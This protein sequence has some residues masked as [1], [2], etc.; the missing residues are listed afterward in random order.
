MIDK[1]IKQL[2]NKFVELNIDGYII[3]KNDEFFS[4]YSAINRLKIISN[5]SGSAGL[6]VV[7][8]KNNYLFVDGRY[9]IQAQ[10]QSGKQFKIIEI[11]KFLPYKIIKNLTLGFDPS[12]LTK[13]QL[14]IYFGNSL[15]LKQINKNLI[16]EI[17][18][19]KIPKTKTFFS[20]NNKVAGES[21]KSKINK[22]INILKSNKADYLFVSAPENVAWVLNIRGSDNPNSPIPNCRL[23][24]RKRKQ[25]FLITQ[26]KLTLKIVNEKKLSKKQIISPEKFKGL[27]KK[28]KGNKFIIDPLSCSIVNENIIKS[29][30][31]II[32]TNDPCY[33]L[34]SIKNS[35]EI[36]NMINAHI[37]DGVAL[38][39]FIYWI[40]NI[41]K[42]KITEINS[43]IKL[44]KF[45]KLNKNYLF[46]SFNTIAATGANAALPHYIAS[47]KS[48][49]II[50]KN[51]IFLCDSGGQYKFGTTDVTRTNCF[52]KQKNSIIDIFTK[53]LKGHIAVATTN[54]KKFNTG[55]KVDARA[56]YFLK[57]DGLDYGHGTGHGVG[58]FSNV[59]EGP[60]TITK[61]NTVKLE[62]GMIVSNEPGYYK[63]GHYGI[64][65]ENLVYIK[66]INNKLFF[67]NLTL[68]P[69]EKDLINFK[70][71]NN[72]EKKYLDNYHKKVYSTLNSYLNRAEKNWLRSF[73]S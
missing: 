55:K 6:A 22:V 29:K 26:E 42:K 10:Q 3:P 35:S 39:K 32:N 51:D 33:K 8:K 58:F 11:H 43:Q 61:T 48:N 20:L 13:K 31:Q 16:D 24:I 4:E 36:K 46:P 63:K 64:R 45:R 38:T 30:F 70:L 25:L 9:T 68:A 5:F 14:N 69:I 54:L 23:I 62:K 41:N 59:H 47:K 60:Q 27:I 73:I 37:K 15:K 7:L 34:K 53:V 49:K 18:K 44:E 66:K 40:K 72:K 50:K 12:L 52:S 17:Y 19:E 28:L 56:R 1:K 2:R 71:L 65:I 21:F 67:E 57:K